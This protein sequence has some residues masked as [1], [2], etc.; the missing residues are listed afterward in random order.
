MACV[1]FTLE[2]LILNF[3]DVTLFLIFTLLASF[4]KLEE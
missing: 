2:H 1:N 3:V 4:L